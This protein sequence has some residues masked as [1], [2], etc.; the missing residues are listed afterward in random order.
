M[1][2][3][4][5]SAVF[6]LLITSAGLLFVTGRTW[7]SL[8]ITEPGVPQFQLAMTGRDLEP[9]VAGCAWALLASAIALL[10]TRG[11]LQR[12]V[13]IIAILLGVVA[14]YSSVQ[15]HQQS[16]NT[17]I[18]Q[19]VAE[20]IG[21]QINGYTQQVTPTWLIAL[22]LAII[23]TLAAIFATLNVQSSAQL[24]QRYE[25]ASGEHEE[26][27]TPWQALDQGLD[28]TADDKPSTQ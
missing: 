26:K 3:S 5:K 21:I 11:V 20:K 8:S 23:S 19:F 14:V 28:P 12:S 6:T 27:L 15:A 9:L 22:V 17:T 2:R 7:I 1:T 4:F 25:R 16:A 10:V 13:G 24:S 18:T